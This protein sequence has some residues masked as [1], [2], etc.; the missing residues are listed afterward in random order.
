MLCD[1]MMGG[2][3]DGL[4]GGRGGHGMGGLA[5]VAGKLRIDAGWEFAR[6]Q[7][8]GRFSQGLV[9]PEI[10]PMSQA[11]HGAPKGLAVIR[12]GSVG[13]ASAPAQGLAAKVAGMASVNAM[14]AGIGTAETLSD[15][16]SHRTGLSES[17]SPPPIHT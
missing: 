17:H 8:I 6:E 10:D 9:L 12:S 5:R 13:S 11:L 1:E 15:A 4:R 16:L 7:V 14:L 2:R 3:D